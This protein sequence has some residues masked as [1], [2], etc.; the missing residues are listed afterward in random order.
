M[1]IIRRLKVLG[2]P[3]PE[4]LNVLRQQIL[5]ICE[6]IVAYWGPMITKEESNMLERCLNTG[7]HI[8]YQEKYIIFEQILKLANMKSLKHERWNL[9]PALVRDM[10]SSEAG[11]LKVK[12]GL[13]EPE[14]EQ[15]PSLSSSQ[16]PAGPTDS[17]D[18]A[19]P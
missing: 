10:P 19:S 1:W 8:I 9:S 15:S 13:L 17:S 14:Q 2:C 5:L 3:I 11:S 6:G 18:P 16:F 7:L 12:P 4:L